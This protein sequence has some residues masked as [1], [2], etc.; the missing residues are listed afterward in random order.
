[1]DE[2]NP[3]LR[4]S[5][6]AFL[7]AA[8]TAVGSA[9]IGSVIAACGGAP[10]AAPA[11][12]TAPADQP[13]AAPGATTAPA[14]GEAP[15]PTEAPA[16]PAEQSAP[17][18]ET[19]LP[20]SV[21]RESV[22]VVDQI[23]RY[24]VVENFNF[25]VS[26]PPSPTRQGLVYDTLWYLDQET[27]EWINA[28]A[29]DKPQYNAD[30]TEMTVKLRKGIL[31]SDGVE[32]SADDVVFTV[33]TLKNTPGLTWSA[34]MGL[35]V[36]DI[37]KTDDSTVVFT[38]NEPNPRFHAFFTARYNAVYM[39][40]KHVWEKAEDLKTFANFPPVSLGAYVYEEGD[41]NGFWELW[42]RR[43]DWDKTT[44][45]VVTGKQ[46]PEYIMSIF[47]GDSA[48]KAIAVSRHNLDILFDAD[49]EAFQAIQASTPSFRS[50]FA[51]FPWAYPNE[52][53]YRYFGPNHGVAPYDNKDVRWALALAT[54]VVDLQTNYIGGVTRITPLPL[55][56]TSLLMELYH[57]PLEPWLK[58]L[59]LDLGG[60]ESY[61]PY[62][63]DVPKKVAAWAR[64]Q[65]YT[66]P[67]DSDAAGLRDRF[68]MG[69]WKYD[70]DAAGK[71]LTKAGFTKGGDG[72]WLKPDGQPWSIKVLAAPDENDV[73][74]LAIGFQD[75]MKTFGVDVEVEAL[76]RQPYTE[77]QNTGDFEI[78]SSWGMATPNANPDLWQ[79]LNSVHSRFFTPVGTSTAGSGS[80][81]IVR[82]KAPEID[83]IVDELAKI[84][85]ED[86]KVSELGQ[87][88]MKVW[89]EN[90]LT[91]PTISFKKFTSID[92]TYWT[93]WPTSENPERQPLYW[94][95]GGRFTFADVEPKA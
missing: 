66:V 33:T 25:F 69:W 34:E 76:D 18:A 15:A 77:R 60:G 37:Q 71:L 17:A 88:A 62:D 48:K 74:R 10:P 82:F 28:L 1:M 64:E 79:G 58:E 32:F 81:N 6:R 52:L 4:L 73:Y 9:A 5:R 20:V 16:A 85:P 8:A 67:E 91:I 42:K 87:N 23:F 39:M 7:R 44:V 29:E 94:F 30:S 21:P 3:R 27:G 31:W 11:A 93:N 68:G 61:Q 55:P 83:T 47:Y 13:T 50:W 65:G 24:S 78:T 40:A 51:D 54:D 45:G 46:G 49:I 26:G 84:S 90:M 19:G 86:P 2:Q 53:D 35:Y 63:P 43:E 75:Q 72:K 92:E 56:A 95:M 22:L 89:V 12:T 57:T 14:E 70:P 59:T 38:L 36:K 80:G 41:P